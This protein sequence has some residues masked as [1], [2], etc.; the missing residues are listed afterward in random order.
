[1]T[2]RPNN[3][4]WIDSFGEIA[5]ELDEIPFI[6]HADQSLSGDGVELFEKFFAMLD[7]L[8]DIQRVFHH[9]ELASL[10]VLAFL[11]D[12]QKSAQCIMLDGGV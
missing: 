5:F 4:Y 10:L 11:G 12:Y 7:E 1:M 9:I 8:D 6:A 3:A 2:S